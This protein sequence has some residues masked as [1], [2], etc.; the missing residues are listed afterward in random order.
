MEYIE[1]KSPGYTWWPL[2]NKLEKMVKFK[3]CNKLN[4]R[5]VCLLCFDLQIKFVIDKF[6][7]KQ[8]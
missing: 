8:F 2:H 3:K 1:Q 5:N 4:T 7:N 6:F